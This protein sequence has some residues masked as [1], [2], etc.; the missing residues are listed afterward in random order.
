MRWQKLLI[1]AS[2]SASLCAAA[3][4][5]DEHGRGRWIGIAAD[6]ETGD[7]FEEGLSFSGMWQKDENGSWKIA[8][9]MYN[10]SP[11]P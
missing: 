2:L 9:D 10:A 4:H 11:A 6:I 1:I 8:R 5:T 3:D 7:K